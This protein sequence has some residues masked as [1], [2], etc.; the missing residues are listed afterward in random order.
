MLLTFIMFCFRSRVKVHEV[1]SVFVRCS[2]QVGFFA[3]ASSC[4]DFGSFR[5]SFCVKTDRSRA[6]AEE[7]EVKGKISHLLNGRLALIELSH[8]YHLLYHLYPLRMSREMS[9]NSKVE[10]IFKNVGE[11]KEIPFRFLFSGSGFFSF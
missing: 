5:G 1:I 7:S 10:A 2:A 8:L 4:F 9:L 6:E 11:G 3:K